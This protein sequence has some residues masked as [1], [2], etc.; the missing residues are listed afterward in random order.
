MRGAKTSK[1]KQQVSVQQQVL[2]SNS[3]K[4]LITKQPFDCDTSQTE[5][6]WLTT[7]T[8]NHYSFIQAMF[9]QVP[10]HSS[11]EKLIGKVANY[12]FITLQDKV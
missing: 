1:Q 10:A 6:W 9:N 4:R 5:V 7:S 8:V 11:S 3:G 2:G 12:S